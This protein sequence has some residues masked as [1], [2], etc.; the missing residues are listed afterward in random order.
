VR[1]GEWEGRGEETTRLE[2]LR[3]LSWQIQ[4]KVVSIFKVWNGRLIVL[5]WFAVLFD[6]WLGGAVATLLLL[7]RRLEQVIEGSEFGLAELLRVLFA[8][9]TKLT[10][11]T[12]QHPRRPGTTHN[13]TTTTVKSPGSTKGHGYERRRDFVKEKRKRV[14]LIGLSGRDRRGGGS[15]S[16]IERKRTSGRKW[17]K[18]WGHFELSEYVRK[19]TDG[20]V[21]ASK[22]QTNLTLGELWDFFGLGWALETEGER[23][24]DR[25]EWGETER[26]RERA[27]RKSEYKEKLSTDIKEKRNNLLHV[28][29]GARVNQS[30]LIVLS[31]T[32][33]PC[34]Y[35]EKG[36][37]G[38]IQTRSL[39]VTSARA[40]NSILTAS[41]SP[42]DAACINAFFP[43]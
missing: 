23:E 7:T 40:S 2:D 35:V 11:Q 10:G 21:S 27:G 32:M 29:R 31:V 39:S 3:Q 36:R 18:S 8:F 41:T 30:I 38:R 17:R 13:I 33:S 26:D 28:S 15:L 14:Q 42:R 16:G 9:Q 1:R 22:R 4:I 6:V 20:L 5:I 43:H 24:K 37:G 19:G 25:E 34:D 12:L